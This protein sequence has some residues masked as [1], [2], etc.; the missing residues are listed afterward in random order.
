[1]E[2]KE[3][4]RMKKQ[5]LALFCLSGALIMV[6]LS[7]CA[8]EKTLET[9]PVVSQEQSKEETQEESSKIQ[10]TKEQAVSGFAI[11][12]QTYEDGENHIEYPHV[13]GLMNQEI[14]DWYNKKFEEPKKN[15]ER[16][17]QEGEAADSLEERVTVTYQTEDEISILIKGYY[18]GGAHP[19]TYARTYN[20]NL[21]TGESTSIIDEISPKQLSEYLLNQTK[22][23]PAGDEEIDTEHLKGEIQMMGD[24]LGETTEN[25]DYKFRK[26]ESG[27]MTEGEEEPYMYSY[28]TEDGKWAIILPVSHVLGDYAFLKFE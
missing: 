15:Y 20:I 24:W 2:K 17:K 5:T 27:K 16:E 12:V 19:S 7:G 18:S 28:K 26:S 25:C 21:K 8:K 14:T 9:K 4:K 1:M 10:E 11:T 23:T 3:T 13:E 22:F 6:G